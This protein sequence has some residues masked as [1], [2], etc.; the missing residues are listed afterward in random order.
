[1]KPR[2]LFCRSNPIA[3]DPRV[4]KEARALVNAGYPV[5]VLGWDRTA[6]LLQQEQTQGFL[7]QRLVIKAVGGVGLHNLPQLLRWQWGLLRWLVWHR[8]EYDL[9]HACDFDTI[10]PALLCKWFLRKSVVYDIFD[11]YADMLRLTPAIVVHL[12]RTAELWAIGQADAVI[13]ADEVRTEQIQGARPKRCVA[14]YNCPEEGE[15][16]SLELTPARPGSESLR[17]AYVGNLQIQRGLLVLLEVLHRHPEWALDL[18]GFGPD[19]EPILAKIRE[20]PNVTWHGR[21]SYS[22]S[23]ELNRAA[24][25]LLATYDPAIPNNRYSSSN[26]LFEAMLLGKPVIV[27]RFTNMDHIVEKS[28]CGLVV[29]YGSVDELEAVLLRLQKE[30]DLRGRLGQQARQAYES[31]YSWARMEARLLALYQEVAA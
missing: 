13:L 23:L 10:L 8:R 28:G 14:V 11:F 4:E 31:T 1:M 18:A 20:M 30:P 2:I 26:K 17:L 9:I 19:E 3:P 21:V 25:V 27:A 5:Q 24:D 6:T 22:R 16:P 12:V 29:T 7:V 15:L